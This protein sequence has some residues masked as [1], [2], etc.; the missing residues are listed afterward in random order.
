[1]E[2]MIRPPG[3][4]TGLYALLAGGLAATLLAPPPGTAAE[5]HAAVV[6]E[7]PSGQTPHLAPTDGVAHP[8]VYALEQSDRTMYV[9]GKFG[10]LQDPE[11]T[12]TFARRSLAAFS[13]ET[14]AVDG[15]FLPRVDGEVWAVRRLGP[16]LYV[17]GTF[18]T[19]DGVARR[20][21]AKLNATTGRLDPTFSATSVNGTITDLRIVDGRLIVGGQFTKRLAALDLVTGRDT[22]YLDLDIAGSAGGSG[23]ATSVY[24]FAVAGTKLVAVGN[25]GTV[26]GQVRERAFMVELGP[27]QG[28]LDPWYYPHLQKTC[29]FPRK[30][31]AYL[32]DVDFAPD[33]SWFVLV[34]TG[35]VP[36]PGEGGLSL[37]D[38]AAR[39]ETRIKRQ[40]K[41]T[42]INY[43]GGDTL[44]SVAVTGAAVYVSGHQR[45]L[46][47]KGGRDFCAPGCVSRP[48]IGALDPGTG[49]AL[50][51]NPTKS[52]AVGGKELLATSQGLWVGSDGQQYAREH[53]YGIAFAPLS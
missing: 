52:R 3:P 2:S 4:R 7:A 6:R 36:Q 25:V 24:R 18:R 49:R 38:A 1:M 11:R 39:F 10:A 34:S 41:P 28:T 9:G 8:A 32:R 53:H 27:A 42:W 44:H 33:G 21:V 15:R 37:C 5:R 23:S 45:W 17:G 47:N 30:L 43:T 16:S 35:G 19:V 50:D 31:P 26:A 12:R 51:W 13:V 14:G 22:G 48:G 29:R 40:D 46:D 20:G